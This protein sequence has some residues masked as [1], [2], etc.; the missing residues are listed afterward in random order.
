MASRAVGVR[1][2]VRTEERGEIL[3]DT[4]E[5]RGEDTGRRHGEKTRGDT[6]RICGEIRGDAVEVT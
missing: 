4:K 1:R 3:G 6:R 2:A 5:I